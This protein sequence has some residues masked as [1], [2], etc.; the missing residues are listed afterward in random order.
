MLPRYRRYAAQG[1]FCLPHSYQD[2][3]ATPL[4]SF[5]VCRVSTK[6][7]PL[8]GSGDHLIFLR[9]TKIS[10]LCGSGDHLICLRATKISPLCGSG[11]F[12]FAAFLPRHQ[13]YAPQIL[14]GVPRFYQDIAAMRLGGSFDMPSCYQDIA[15]MRLRGFF[16]YRIVTKTSGLRPSNPSWFAAFLPRHR[17]YA[18]RGII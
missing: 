15:A 10:P 6:T 13:G 5:M 7:S 9:A 1:I 16:V 11:D 12:L 17:R 4:K 2:I 14:H 18:A 8:C 3:R